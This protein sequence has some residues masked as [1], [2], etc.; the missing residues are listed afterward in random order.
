MEAGVDI[1]HI[2]YK[3]TS[4]ALNDVVGGQ[5]QMS[6]QSIVSTIPHIRGG[7]LKGLAVSG[8]SRFPALPQVP[9]FAESGLPRVEAKVVYGILAPAD[10]PKEIV[11]KLAAEIAGIQRTAEF[12]QKLAAQGVE[13]YIL[14]P[15]QFA[16]TIKSDMATNAKIIKAANI[17]IEH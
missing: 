15:E 14:G 2:P 8:D 13:V 4:Q 1:V 11:G 7:R 12:K 10:T 6:I 3:G 17:K 16:A 9:T 5:V